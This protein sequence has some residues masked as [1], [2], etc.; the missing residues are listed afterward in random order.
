MGEA[1]T[2]LDTIRA[3]FPEVHDFTGKV[4]LKGHGRKSLLSLLRA[5]KATEGIEIG[6][7]EAQFAEQMFA[8]LPG[9]HLV[10]IDAWS[11]YGRSCGNPDL[12][13][14]RVAE[15]RAKARMAGYNWTLMRDFSQEAAKRVPD[16]SVDFIY[17]DGDH[18]YEGVMADLESWVPKVKPGGIVAGHDYRHFEP[19]EHELPIRVVE[20][21]ND[22]VA[23]HAVDPFFVMDALRRDGQPSY[24]WVQA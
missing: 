14:F 11:D 17:V 4:F 10:G 21:V 20:A 18:R 2:T 12:W 1:V 5:L 7:W 15:R 19:W 16:G 6:V 24:F 9:L 23:A 3:F 13:R 22:Y 8:A